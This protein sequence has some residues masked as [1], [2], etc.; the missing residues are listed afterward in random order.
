MNI[1]Y[2]HTDPVVAAKSLCDKHVVK[3]ILES[4][5]MLSTA[6]HICGEPEKD[7]ME[8]YRKTHINH[9][10]NVWVRESTKHYHWLW[11][12]ALALCAEYTERY[13]KV[14][15]TENMLRVDLP[16]YPYAMKENNFSEPPQCMPEQYKCDDAVTAYRNYYIG[17][18]AYMATWKQNRPDWFVL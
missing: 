10:S 13:G 17:D 5:Q 4:A 7:G 15:K 8:I 1:F 16:F 2:V 3:M 6:H 12:H 18:K 9:P 14:H 11:E